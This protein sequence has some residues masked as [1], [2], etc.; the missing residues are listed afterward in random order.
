MSQD[1]HYTLFTGF[2]INHHAQHH[3]GDVHADTHMGNG[4]PVLIPTAFYYYKKNGLFEFFEPIKLTEG[5]FLP[6]YTPHAA[7]TTPTTVWTVV[8]QSFEEATDTYLH[9]IRI[10]TNHANSDRA[11][12]SSA[13]TKAVLAWARAWLP[14]FIRHAHSQSHQPLPPDLRTVLEAVHRMHDAAH[15]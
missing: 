8:A 1:Y 15:L 7:S 3:G 5:A 12:N 13:M 4:P 11:E 9:G 6:V 2:E 10:A 14:H